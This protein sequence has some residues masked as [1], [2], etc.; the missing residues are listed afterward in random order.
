MKQCSNLGDKAFEVDTTLIDAVIVF[1]SK[2]IM[3]SMLFKTTLNTVKPRNAHTIC[4]RNSARKWVARKGCFKRNTRFF[5]RFSYLRRLSLS[6][7]DSWYPDK[8]PPTKFPPKKSLWMPLS[9]NLLKLESSI[10]TRAKRAPNR[11]NVATEKR[12]YIFFF[13]SGGFL[14]GGFCRWDFIREPINS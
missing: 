10:L 12:S 13:F 1:W 5:T 6:V 3:S 11:N 8:I 9:A 4:S 14:S 2:G 7:T